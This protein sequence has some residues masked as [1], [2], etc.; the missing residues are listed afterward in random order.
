VTLDGRSF[1][2]DPLEVARKLRAKPVVEQL[3]L[4]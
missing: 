3:S 1:A 4:F 2:G